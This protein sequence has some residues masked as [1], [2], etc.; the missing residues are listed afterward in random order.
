M[1]IYDE[2]TA[3]R[4]TVGQEYFAIAHPNLTAINHETPNRTYYQ[5]FN[6]TRECDII[7]MSQQELASELRKSAEKRAAHKKKAIEPVSQ[8]QSIP[9]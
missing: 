1:N 7:Q 4:M 2:A 6:V 9:A 3:K 5:H 8:P